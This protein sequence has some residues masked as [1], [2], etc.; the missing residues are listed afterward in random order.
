MMKETGE[1]NMGPLGYISYDGGHTWFQQWMDERDNLIERQVT[2][3]D[4]IGYA[5][6]RTLKAA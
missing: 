3:K 6:W 2:G 4:S 5:K 1:N